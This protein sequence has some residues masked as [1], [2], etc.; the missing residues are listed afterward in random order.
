MTLVYST[1][2]LHESFQQHQQASQ[3]HNMVCVACGAVTR[4]ICVAHHLCGLL[5]CT[6]PRGSSC[7]CTLSF[8]RY[9]DVL[10]QRLCLVVLSV[11]A[12]HL[13]SSGTLLYDLC[14][15]V[16][17][18]LSCPMSIRLLNEAMFYCT[19]VNLYPVTFHISSAIICTL[20]LSVTNGS[21]AMT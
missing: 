3:H 1:R 8:P 20:S 11:G 17:C 18:R 10:H 13:G 9:H 6:R 14:L 2:G 15:K 5:S 12:P 4:L 16:G 7:S 19:Y 21:F